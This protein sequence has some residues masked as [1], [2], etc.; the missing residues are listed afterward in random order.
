MKK[1]VQKIVLSLG[2]MTTL[3]L[4]GQQNKLIPCDT[5]NAMETH[6]KEDPQ[7]KIRFDRVQAEINLIRDNQSSN[8]SKT[9]INTYTIPV[10]FHVL[11]N[12][13]VENIP[14]SQCITALAEVNKMYSRQGSD[15]ASIAAPF[16]AIYHDSG[17]RFV[18]A[19]KDP[20]GNCTTGIEH[21]YDARTTWDRNP[22]NSASYL[23]TGLTWN[24]TKYL[25]IIVVKDIVAAPGQQGVVQGYTYLP[26][27]WAL[28]ANQ[29]AVV[30][31]YNAMTGT[32]ARSIAHEFGHW[33][34]LA[35]TFGNTNNP[36]I[37]CGDDGIADTPPTKGYFSTC[38][39]SLNGN[40]CATANTAWYSAGMANVEN[41]MDYSSCPKNFT[42]GQITNVVATLNSPSVGRN[43]LWS[44]NNLIATDVA[45]TGICAPTANFASTTGAYTVCSGNSLSMRDFSYNGII[46][47]YNWSTGSG[48]T[49]ASPNAANT[50]ITF[51][52]VGTTNVSLTVSNN[53]GSSTK[54]RQVVVRDATPGIT[55]PTMESFE[56]D[57]IPAGWNVINQNLNSAKWKQTDQAAYDGLYSFYVDGP[58]SGANQTDILETP[59]I[60]VL[61]NSDKTFTIAVAY[62]QSNA[63]YTDQLNIDGSVDC[64]ATWKNIANL[65]AAQMRQN[66]GGITSSPWYP[67]FETDWRVWN[68]GN[69]PVWT[70]DFISSPNVKLRFRFTE[71]APGAGN[72]IFLDAINL[73]GYVAGVGINEL[74]KKY[75]FYVYP[76]PSNGLANIKFNLNDQSA[77]KLAVYDVL[78]H[79]VESLINANLKPG[80]Q[81]VMINKTNNLAPGVYIINLEVNGTKMIK[82][83]VIN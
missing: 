17:V 58:T 49:I 80:E 4:F 79:Q 39:G 64:G 5:Y 2:L 72:N 15:T 12:S 6:F 62:A 83:L 37:T 47:S 53:Q 73:F 75:S 66:S 26:G 35:H 54:V 65:T 59:I 14:D 69:Y 74:T 78:G 46:N 71:S 77:V 28:G 63:T 24:P 70:S 9:T 55:F 56:N 81:N 19:H 60:D 16:K 52:T 18:L 31:V 36:G 34:S 40:T 76:N 10:V 3:G 41:I 25:N 50:N 45:G 67:Q 44:Q 29:D 23:F 22:S 42:D 30:F 57:T 32:N 8:L 7:A 48:A 1:Q 27:T 21:I 51:N 43:N 13:G 11:H 20:N 61:N 33:F 68:I 38:P 82:K